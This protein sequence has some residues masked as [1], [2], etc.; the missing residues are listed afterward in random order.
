MG[1]GEK[2][3]GMLNGGMGNV[4]GEWGLGNGVGE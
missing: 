3:L 1:N 2:G 4:T